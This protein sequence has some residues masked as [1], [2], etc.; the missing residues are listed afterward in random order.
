MVL[1][2]AAG[3]PFLH[4][5]HVARVA[6]LEVGMSHALAA[7][8]QA[9]SKLLRF[10]MDVTRPPH[11]RCE[12]LERAPAQWRLPWPAWCRNRWQ[13]AQCARHRQS[14]RCFCETIF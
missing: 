1:T 6:Q 2:A 8:E 3:K 4:A 5:L 10:L 9:V 13:N 12:L 14:A 11:C 7:G